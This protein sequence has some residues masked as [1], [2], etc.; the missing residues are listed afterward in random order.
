MNE[1]VHCIN[2]EGKKARN[3]HENDDSDFLWALYS[4]YKKYASFPCKS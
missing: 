2:N 3:E 1:E 4:V